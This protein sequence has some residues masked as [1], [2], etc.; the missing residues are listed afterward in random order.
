MATPAFVFKKGDVI[1]GRYEIHTLL[2]RGGFGEVYL[3]Y[4]RSMREAC[5]LKTIRADFSTDLF[6][7]DVFRKEALL[8]VNLERHPF[9]V[10]A[11]WVGEFSGRLF[12]E[13]DYIAPDIWGRVSLADHLMR[14]NGS[15]D[16]IRVL[17]WAIEFCAGMSH[18][19]Q[20]GLRCHRDIK[21]GN[22]LIT[23]DGTLKICDFG[24]GAAAEA[25]AT[26]KTA[27]QPNQE[28]HDFRFSFLQHD[29]RG[30]C[31]TPGYMAPEMILGREAD[32]RSD[33]YSF[34]LVLWQI[35]ASSPVPPFH[36]AQAKDADGYI[37]DVFQQQIRGRVP[38]GGGL[39]QD[40]V[41]QCLSPEP[42][43]RPANFAVLQ[44]EFER[45]FREHTG[46]KFQIIISDE[47]TASFWND[48][49]ASLFALGQ[50]KEAVEYFDRAIDIDPRVAAPW[51]NKGSAL[52]RMGDP[53]GAIVCFSRALAID[54]GQ[55]AVW[56]NNGLALY[57]L[58]RLD[59]ALECFSTALK[60]NPRYAGAWQG[61]GLT[62]AALGNLAQSIPCFSKAVEIEPNDAIS[63]YSLGVAM[64]ALGRH[65]EEIACY[66]RAVEI[67]PL[68]ATAW[69][70]KGAALYK[71][72]RY[73]EAI[74]C[75]SRA[76]E[77]NPNEP[78]GWNNMGLAMRH[79][80]EGKPATP[81]T[82]ART[83]DALQ[84][85]SRAVEAQPDDARA[86]LNKGIMEGE[87]LD[88][89]KSG[90]QSLRKYLQLAR[91]IASEAGRIST[92]ENVIDD[93]SR[94]TA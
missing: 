14:P 86:W 90:V 23:Q 67:D 47:K 94:L 61:K 28:P 59:E 81:D 63:W 13:M 40:V 56:G 6:S 33:I 15:I 77:I 48:K 57:A 36:S 82:L 12:V 53:R 37:R 93:W 74:G 89:R 27:A 84:C 83:K 2:G 58:E 25:M 70:N 55:A 32:I 69:N 4:D 52:R 51:S 31:G 11:R 91:G 79:L 41:E 34:G 21:P 10:S 16:V 64:A 19:N 88:D 38:Q 73:A 80:I 45:R 72:G 8:W 49:G 17:M 65:E 26:T 39:L 50:Q 62:L 35:A 66:S 85:F 9:I 78:D 43:L 7:R 68:H 1:G 44:A 87:F 54:P 20:R 3:A 18:A 42:S 22:I 46:R 5:A 60:I 71:L 30:V 92:I 75:F 29:G 76:V 24:L